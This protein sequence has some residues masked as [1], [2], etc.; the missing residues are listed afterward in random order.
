MKNKKRIMKNKKQTKEEIAPKLNKTCDNCRG[1]RKRKYATHYCENCL[2]TFCDECAQ[3]VE[4][5]CPFC[6]PILKEIKR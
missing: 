5:G 2:N 1:N 6:A 3:E 4:W